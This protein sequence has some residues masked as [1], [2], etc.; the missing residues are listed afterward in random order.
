[1]QKTQQEELEQIEKTQKEQFLEFSKSWDKYMADYEE[2]AYVS[3]EKLKA[4][5]DTEIMLLREQLMNQYNLKYTFS[6]E[7]MELRAMEKKHFALKQYQKADKLR[8]KANAMEL[9]EKKVQE[10]SIIDKIERAETK[11][12]QKQQATLQ[13][14]LKRI[15]RDRDEQLK[16]R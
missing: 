2:A 8:I 3:L 11:L 5:H 4:K 1:M 16:H 10:L 14:L 15:Q 7:L 9:E 13:S 12:R 6:K